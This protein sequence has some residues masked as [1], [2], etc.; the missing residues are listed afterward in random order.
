MYVF[1]VFDVPVDQIRFRSSA[2]GNLFSPSHRAHRV[3]PATLHNKHTLSRF[4]F[5]L[6]ARDANKKEGKTKSK[7]ERKRGKG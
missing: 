7:V 4:Q 5:D 2:P 3:D 6:Q 1:C